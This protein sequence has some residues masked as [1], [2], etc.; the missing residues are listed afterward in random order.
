MCW[1]VCAIAAAAALLLLRRCCCCF[2]TR[3]E[4]ARLCSCACLL[5]CVLA[6]SD[7]H[8]H[9]AVLLPEYDHKNYQYNRFNAS[10][11]LTGPS[12]LKW[13][14]RRTPDEDNDPRFPDF[15]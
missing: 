8:R 10:S 6:L 9:V 11:T 2:L 1:R 12:G 14:T 4:F 13:K 15:W 5:S 3:P 7:L